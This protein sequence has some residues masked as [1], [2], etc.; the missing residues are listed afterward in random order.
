MSKTLTDLRAFAASA[1]AAREYV[2]RAGVTRR[3]TGTTPRHARGQ[4]PL[5]WLVN[6]RLSPV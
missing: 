3:G 4:P 5:G 6:D 2:A 1:A